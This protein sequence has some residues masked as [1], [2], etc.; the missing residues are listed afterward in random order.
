MLPTSLAALSDAFG[1]NCTLGRVAGPLQQV[2]AGTDRRSRRAAP[3]LS[4]RLCSLLQ[5]AEAPHGAVGSRR[6]G[7]G[8][9]AT[10]PAQ[11]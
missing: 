10:Y 6:Q 2:A 11:F 7:Y 9:Q 8:Y 1:S 5:G 4:H 3:T